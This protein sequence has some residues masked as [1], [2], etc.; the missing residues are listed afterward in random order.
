MIYLRKIVNSYNPQIIQGHSTEKFAKFGYYLAKE[1]KIPF[2]YD[3]HG[4]NEDSLV[5]Q[6]ILKKNSRGYLKKKEKETNL[7]KK[8]DAVVAIGRNMKEDL[9][10]RGIDEKKIIIVDN[11]VDTNLLKPISPDIRLKQKLGISDKKIIGYVGNVRRIEGLDILFKAMNILKKK[12]NNIFLLIV[13]NYNHDYYNYLKILADK[14][15]INKNI[16]FIGPVP[17]S[18]VY[19]YYSIIDVNV[20]PRINIRVNRLVTPLKPL[21][22]MA[23]SKVVIASDLPALRELIKPKISGDLFEAGNYE[24]LAD[25]LLYYLSNSDKREDLGKRAREYVKRKFDWSIIIKDYLILYKKLLSF[26]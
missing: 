10:S 2:I 15:E 7:M 17:Y 6:G 20:I 22:V 18:E 13:G 12:I 21:D 25:C 4:F 11:G 14:L 24:K 5:G 19:R 16:K 8:A 3:V 9:I 1:K 23:M 26:V